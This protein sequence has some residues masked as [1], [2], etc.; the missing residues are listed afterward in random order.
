MK[1]IVYSI[2]GVTIIVLSIASSML[3]PDSEYEN[4]CIPPPPDGLIN[5]N[6]SAKFKNCQ[7]TFFDVWKDRQSLDEF[8][9][10]N[11]GGILGY[12]QNQEFQFCKTVFHSVTFGLKK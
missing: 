8:L 12:L 5:P 6:F 11:D 9:F 2:V 3:L 10:S 1:N 4:L 7:I